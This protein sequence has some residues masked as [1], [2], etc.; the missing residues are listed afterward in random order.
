MKLPDVIHPKRFKAGDVLI[1]VATY[2]PVTDRQASLIAMRFIRTTKLTKKQRQKGT[3]LRTH[4]SGDRESL[5]LLEPRQ[6]P[7]W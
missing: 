4:W 3:L 7:N 1:E 5:A 6:L 2:F